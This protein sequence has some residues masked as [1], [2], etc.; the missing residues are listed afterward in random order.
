M[1]QLH[2]PPFYKGQETFSIKASALPWHI[3]DVKLDSYWPHTCAGAGIL[4][5]VADT[6]IDET[7]PDIAGRIRWAQAF[8]RRRGRADRVDDG[9]G[10]GTHVA[11]TI[12]TMAPNAEF[13]IAKVLADNGSGS[14]R[15]VA[16]GIRALADQGCHI[17]NLSLGGPY[18]DPDTRDAVDYA[19]RAGCL[20]FVATG[21]ENANAVGFPA[22]HAVGV[23]AVG[24]DRK[25]AWFSNRGKNVDIVGYG[26]EIIAGVPGGTWQEMSGTSMATPW[27]AGIAANRLSAELK[28]RGEVYTNSDAR[29]LELETF[30]TDLGPAGRDTSYGRGMP[31]LAAVLNLAEPEPEPAGDAPSYKLSIFADGKPREAEGTFRELEQ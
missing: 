1:T 25:L 16:T 26:V 29:L 30:V 23:G 5:G 10:H 28:H 12:A 9:N 7:H 31:D 21:N 17:I 24:R 4:V 18:D 22:Q 11:T 14:N 27:I 19:K 8:V 3:T 15:G 6:G 2:L 20:V 13:A